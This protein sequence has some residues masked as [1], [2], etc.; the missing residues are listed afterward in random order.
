MDVEAVLDQVAKRPAVDVVVSLGGIGDQLHGGTDRGDP[1]RASLAW[2]AQHCPDRR[3][4]PSSGALMPRS[5]TLPRSVPSLEVTRNV[6]PSLIAEILPLSTGAELLDARHRPKNQVHGGLVHRESRP[7]ADP[8]TP[9]PPAARYRQGSRDENRP[10]T[11][12]RA[13]TSRAP[14]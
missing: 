9:R 1:E 11:S 5:L 10:A 3:S 13:T 8:G 12:P 2:A 14:S 4:W 7:T 6:S